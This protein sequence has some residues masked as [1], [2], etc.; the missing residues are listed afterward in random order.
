MKLVQPAAL[1]ALLA[2]IVIAAIYVVRLPFRRRYAVT[3]PTTRAL[4]T[5][6]PRRPG[7]QRH[8]STV[9]FL[10]AIAATA[11]A[12]ARPAQEHTVPNHLGS[13]IVALDTSNSMRATDVKP[14]RLQAAQRAAAQF[15][16]TVPKFVQVGLVTFSGTATVAVP[17]TSD[18]HRLR[19][20]VESVGFGEGTSL[21]EGIR[22]SITAV[23]QQAADLELTAHRSG[24]ESSQPPP[25]AVVMFSDGQQTLGAD[26]RVAVDVARRANVAVSTVAIGTRRGTVTLGGTRIDAPVDRPSLAAVA[27]STHGHAYID[28][29]G[30]ELG[31]VYE[32]LARRLGFTSDTRDLTGWLLG[33]ALGLGAAA[34]VAAF[35]WGQRVP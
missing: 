22:A 15:I 33:V 28:R 11:L 4:A 26:E 8:A 5:V 32:A 2:V 18:R 25:S 14:Q 7:W 35:V 23:E 20:A 3:L 24:R 17:P 29:P 19:A 12:F 6:A 1:L 16:G 10:A 27:E 31:A 13:V 30:I 34:L 21:G 9:L